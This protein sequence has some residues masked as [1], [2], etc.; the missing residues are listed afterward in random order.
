M[1][2]Y[3]RFLCPLCQVSVSAA[4]QYAGLPGPCPACGATITV[5]ALPSPSS[6]VKEGV[7]QAISWPNRPPVN[8][9]LPG[10]G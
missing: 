9:S 10:F 2:A 6:A 1:H 8:P 7:T 4:P 3:V 5:P